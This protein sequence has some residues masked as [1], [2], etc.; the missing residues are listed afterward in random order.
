MNAYTP[1]QTEPIRDARA[2]LPFDAELSP[3]RSLS[4][5]GF[6]ALMAAICGVSFI[7]GVLFYQL[8]AWPVSFFFGV[9]ALL[10]YGAFRLNY[11]DG[12][13][14]ETIRVTQDA[15]TLTR[16]DTRGR[17]RYKTFEPAWVRVVLNE[18]ANGKTTIALAEKGAKTEFGGFLT[19][20][21]RRDFSDQLARVLLEARGGAR[22]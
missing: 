13:R 18:T 19:D 3:H 16:Y 15:V 12:R 4:N 5:G 20:D 21:E 10:V 17:S 14:R 1:S 2:M 9:D 7:S 22:I 8:G 11:R 6:L